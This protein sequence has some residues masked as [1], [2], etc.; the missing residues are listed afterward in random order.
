[1]L[2]VLVLFHRETSLCFL[3]L[4]FSRLSTIILADRT[5]G[6]GVRRAHVSSALAGDIRTGGDRG[7]FEYATALINVNETAGSV[8]AGVARSRREIVSW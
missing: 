1:M 3:M 2:I 7:R 4:R 6:T 5:F 8:A